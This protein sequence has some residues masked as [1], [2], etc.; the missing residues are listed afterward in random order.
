MK[1]HRINLGNASKGFTIIELLMATAVFGA[2]L[3]VITTA[4]LQ[5]S[6]VYYK[7]ITQAKTQNAT[8]NIS[9]IIGQGIQ[10]SGGQV[11]LTN[12]SP[13]AGS[14][15]A[16]CINNQQYSYTLGY[17]LSDSP[18]SSQTYHGL[19]VRDTACT[20][21][22]PAQNVRSSTVD[23]RELLDPNMRLSNLVVQQVTT[24]V[25]KVTVKV[26]YGDD[27][28]VKNNRGTNATC[29]NFRSGTQFCAVAE[30]TTIVTKRVK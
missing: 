10:F 2:I 26:V 19:V 16:F 17:Q 20:S 25:Y 22:T 28:L 13:T 21:A 27:D 24:G 29:Q 7:G 5:I 9:D 6:R 23:G 18:T 11:T 3:L 15:Y 12:T 30:L 8:R 14:S 4:I 1:L